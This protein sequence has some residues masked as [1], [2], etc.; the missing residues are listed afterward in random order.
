VE[1]MKS[2][3]YYK[4]GDLWKFRTSSGVLLD[5]NTPDPNEDFDDNEVDDIANQ[6]NENQGHMDVDE[7]NVHQENEEIEGNDWNPWVGGATLGWS[8]RF[9]VNNEG[10]NPWVHN[11]AHPSQM[12]WNASSYDPYSHDDGNNMAH[13]VSMMENM[14]VQQ[15]QSHTDMLQGFNHINANMRE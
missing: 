4:H 11:S 7:E 6:G 14:R 13:M 15:I 5:F 3:H 1:T 2:C 10:W 8:D 12:S 9:N